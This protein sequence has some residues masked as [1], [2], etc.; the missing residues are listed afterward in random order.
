MLSVPLGEAEIRAECD[1]ALADAQKSADT[2]TA[3]RVRFYLLDTL[4]T[5][6]VG[7]SWFRPYEPIEPGSE[8]FPDEA[9]RT[10]ANL[11]ENCDK[12]RI[13]VPAVP[14][15]R[16][17]LAALARHELEHAVQFEAGVG[18]NDCHDVI[19]DR[20]LPEVAGDLD[21]CAGA[22]INSIPTEIDC[23]AAASVYIASR[24]S[25]REVQAVRDGPRGHLACSLIEPLPPDTLPARMV[26]FAFV[27][28]AALE[29]YAQ[30]R[31][32]TVQSVVSLMHP[33]GPKWW[34]RLEEAVV[35]RGD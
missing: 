6:H 35:N 24:F 29:R 10:F 5:G 2:L 1:L 25:A 27:H 34:E 17:T 4:G 12:H 31:N 11:P 3:D 23:N 33:Q 7:A 22:L 15:D 28:R 8:A 26:A 20:I 16:P 13:G 21:G 19:R 18:I 32:F 9:Q 30:R 14:T